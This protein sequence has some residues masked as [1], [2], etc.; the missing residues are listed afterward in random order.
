MIKLTDSVS[1]EARARIGLMF[2][3]EERA[4]AERIL[5]D[6][7]NPGLRHIKAGNLDRWHFAALKLSEGEIAKLESAAALGRKDW[8]DLLVAANF[9]TADAYRTWQPG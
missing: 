4:S 8:R 9:G 1:E 6:Q 5:I 7:L 3:L 2:T